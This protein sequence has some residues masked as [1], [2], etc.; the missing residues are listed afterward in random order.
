MAAVSEVVGVRTEVPFVLPVGVEGEG[1]ERFREGVMRFATARDELQALVDPAVRRNEAYLTVLLLARTVVSLGPFDGDDVSVALIEGLFAAD[2]DHLQ[3]LYERCN[4]DA[5]VDVAV[6][7]PGCGETFG[8]DLRDAQD[9]P[10][11]K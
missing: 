3:R 2:F 11:G 7:C 4:S 6:C 8:A 9:L 5:G 1:G 10:P